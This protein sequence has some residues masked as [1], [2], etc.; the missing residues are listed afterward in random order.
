MLKNKPLP[1]WRPLGLAPGDTVKVIA[2]R[3]RAKIGTILRTLP[4]Q[5]K[6]VVQ[7]INLRKR[8]VKAGQRVAGNRIM[9]GG[10]VDFEAPIARSNVMLI[11][12]ACNQ[13]TRIK[14]IELASGEKAVECIHCHEPYERVRKV[15]AQ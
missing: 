6:V 13:T 12:P 1:R 11:C 3:E 7:G 8:H 15:E 14:H 4:R 2:G 9:Q 10:I 5:D